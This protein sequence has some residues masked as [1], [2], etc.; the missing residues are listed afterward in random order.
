M[1]KML[2]ISVAVLFTA[3]ATLTPIV[4]QVADELPYKEDGPE[5]DYYLQTFVRA[6]VQ[7][8]WWKKL[9]ANEKETAQFC[10]CK[11]LFVADL[12]T[13]EDDLEFYRAKQTS[14][15]LP[16]ELF[17]KWEKGNLACQKHFSK[18]PKAP[19]RTKPKE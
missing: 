4:A 8:P 2:L 15:K 18:L 13:R 5:R 12:W 1:K 10:E 9:A 17:M 7:E 6:C 16:V 19:T 14:T 11:A 3:S